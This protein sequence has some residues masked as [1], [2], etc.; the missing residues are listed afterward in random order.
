MTLFASDLNMALAFYQAAQK[1]TK[2]DALKSFNKTLSTFNPWR[3]M[4]KRE[5]VHFRQDERALRERVLAT[6]KP[7]AITHYHNDV[8][9][10]FTPS[11]EYYV[12]G[13]I[14][15]LRSPPGL[16]YTDTQRWTADYYETLVITASQTLSHLIPKEECERLAWRLSHDAQR[17]CA[18]LLFDHGHTLGIHAAYLDKVGPR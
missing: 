18:T 11:W 2:S 1:Q 6:L 10:I 8:D 3:E 7:A 16:S 5:Y 12:D 4:S 17:G 13:L 14:H 9:N 15:L